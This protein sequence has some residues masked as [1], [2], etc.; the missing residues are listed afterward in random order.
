MNNKESA[1][2]VITGAASGMGFAS[3]RRLGKRD[4]VLLVDINAKLLDHVADQ[5]LSEGVQAEKHVCDITNE[6]SVR[7][8]AKTA[9]SLGQ[10]SGVVNAAG[11]SPSMADWRR[12]LSVD[13]VGTAFIL[14]EFLPLMAPGSAAVCI[15]S[16]ASRLSTSD[17][18]IDAI[19]D[20][21]LYPDFLKSIEPFLSMPVP[22]TEVDP[23]SGMAYVLAK[24]GVVRLCERL[25]PAWAQRDA[26]IVSISPGN[27]DTP[28]GRLEFERLSYIRE[29]TEKTP[30]RRL[31][32][33]EEIAAAVDFLCSDDA[34]FITGCD[35]LVDG[36]Y[37]GAMS[38]AKGN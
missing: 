25:A 34:S 37:T 1:L 10:V 11:I 26:R 38:H 17:P 36:G 31:G 5:L 21:P 24:R 29:A 22:S 19:I 20:N 27:I 16:I 9:Q 6:H 14:R 35:L 15:A 7:L 8:L 18:K 13:L 3:A 30:I 23:K 12:I 32:R 28:M 33:P 2:F 4:R